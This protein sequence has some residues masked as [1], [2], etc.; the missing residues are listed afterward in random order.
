MNARTLAAQFLVAFA[1]ASLF[2]VIA[3]AKPGDRANAICDREESQYKAPGCSKPGEQVTV[4]GKK[5]TCWS[6]YHCQES[7]D[8]GAR[9]VGTCGWDSKSGKGAC[10]L[11]GFQDAEG[12]MIDL[13]PKVQDP[14]SH[15]LSD[16]PATPASLEKLGTTPPAEPAS[17]LNFCSG[18]CADSIREAFGNPSPLTGSEVAGVEPVAGTPEGTGAQKPATILDE[19]KAIGKNFVALFDSTPLPPQSSTLSPLLQIEALAVQPPEGSVRLSADGQPLPRAYGD[20]FGQAK[21]SQLESANWWRDFYRK[22]DTLTMS[23]Q[24]L[25]RCRSSYCD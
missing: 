19:L 22:F 2:P 10:K 23:I 11:S 25:F 16:K 6:G 21:S 20:T 18:T 12:K 5:I 17:T 4:N 15:Y 7:N 3:S 1:V 24:Y 13:D 8:S 9:V 14:Y